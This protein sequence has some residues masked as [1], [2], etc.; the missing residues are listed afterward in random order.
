MTDAFWSESE[1]YDGPPFKEEMVAAAESMLGYKLP[2]SYI[3]LMRTKNGG[4]PNRVCFPTKVRTSWAENHIQITNIKGLSGKHGITVEDVGNAYMIAEW[5][6]PDVGI[7]IADCPSAGHDV[8]M[9]DYSLCGPEGEP[10]VIH[11]ETECDEPEVLVLA[12]NFKCFV[13]G[14][15]ASSEFDHLY[16]KESD[17]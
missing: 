16:E 6:Y 8:V 12:E 4:E 2:A 15:V 13:D 7:I 9:L 5:G 11:V 1:F 3:E 17:D 10:R 14:L